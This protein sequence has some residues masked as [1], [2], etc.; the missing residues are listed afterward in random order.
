MAIFS[1]IKSKNQNTILNV[2]VICDKVSNDVM[3]KFEHLSC[4]NVIVKTYSVDL[5]K[6]VKGVLAYRHCSKTMYLKM[7]IPSILGDLDKVLYLDSD[8]L[9][10]KDLAEY[11]N[12]LNINE[13]YDIAV[14]KDLGMIKIWPTSFKAYE[15]DDVFYSG[16]ML[17]NLK[18]LRG[19]NGI[20]HRFLNLLNSGKYDISYGDE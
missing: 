4:K 5:D 20:E 1:A 10:R 11:F 12:Q 2:H 14:I 6:Y 18:N 8:I 19:V 15:V 7:F 16:Q 13:N 9:I 17:M 3:R